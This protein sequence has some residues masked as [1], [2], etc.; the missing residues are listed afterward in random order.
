MD[1]TSSVS[2]MPLFSSTSLNV[3]LPAIKSVSDCARWDVVVAPYLPQLKTFPYQVWLHLF[4]LQELQ[5]LYLSTN[6]LI[7][8]FS[9]ALFLTPVVL[10]VSEINK[11][12][13]Q[14]DRLWSLLPSLYHIH[15]AVWAQ[16]NGLPTGKINHVLVFSLFWSVSTSSR[17]CNLPNY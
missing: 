1:F 7:S 8:G 10:I 14:V 9:F 17:H 3:A 6:P 2:T 4:N 12:Y 13:S 15:Y 11:N 5:S 16:M